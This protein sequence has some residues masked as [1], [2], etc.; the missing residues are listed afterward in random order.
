ME[1][2]R[3]KHGIYDTLKRICCTCTTVCM[4][5][6]MYVYKKYTIYICIYIY[7][8]ILFA[9]THTHAHIHPH[10]HTHKHAHMLASFDS[11][12]WLKH[13]RPLGPLKTRKGKNASQRIKLRDVGVEALR[14]SKKPYTNLTTLNPKHL[15]GA[16]A[17]ED[18]REVRLGCHSLIYSGL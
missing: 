4:Y 3:V 16:L 7:Y 10:T 2:N 11:S 18:L 12:T 9:Y 5:V 1:L 13:G 6:C 14:L 8:N 15:C 17:A